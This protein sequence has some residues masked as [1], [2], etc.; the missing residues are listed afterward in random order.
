LQSVEKKKIGDGLIRVDVE[1]WEEG[2]D[3]KSKAY[4]WLRT[5]KDKMF[6]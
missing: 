1:N 5:E 3:T 2:T 4:N 6:D